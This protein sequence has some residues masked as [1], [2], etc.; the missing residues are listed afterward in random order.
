LCA[1]FEKHTIEHLVKWWLISGVSKRTFVRVFKTAKYDLKTCE[2]LRFKLRTLQRRALWIE[3]FMTFS[4]FPTIIVT[5]SVPNSLERRAVAAIL[6][7][8][9]LPT[10]MG[11]SYYVSVW[12]GLVYKKFEILYLCCNGVSRNYSWM[13]SLS[14]VIFIKKSLTIILPRSGEL[15]HPMNLSNHPNRIAHL[16][17]TEM[18][19]V[20][21]LSVLR[22]FGTPIHYV[23]NVLPSVLGTIQQNLQMR[24]FSSTGSN[25]H[26]KVYPSAWIRS[27]CIAVPS[28]LSSIYIRMNSCSS[29]RVGGNR[30]VGPVSD[31]EFFPTLKQSD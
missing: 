22:S 16:I 13:R 27:I 19:Q 2:T 4:A 11:V 21:E 17:C 1:S 15:I 12:H 20:V 14:L 31:L 3:N 28:S 7:W 18:E 10:K 30:K 5:I 8:S 6:V 29:C 9:P 24:Q 25:P 26:E 23:V